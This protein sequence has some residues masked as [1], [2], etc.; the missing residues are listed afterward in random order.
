MNRVI[1]IGGLHGTG[2]S[3]TADIVAEH[4]DLRRVSA[5]RIFRG[6]A[7]ER[8]MTLEEFSK[9]AETDP[10]IDHELDARIKAEARKGSIVLDGQL[11]AWMADDFADL[12]VYLRAPTEVRVKRIASR[13]D[14]SFDNAMKETIV[15]EKIERERY[16][17]F[18][19]VDIRDL[20]IYDLIINTSIYDLEGVASIII[21]AAS[22]L[23]ENQP[24][25][26]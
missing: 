22:Y 20:E 19:G 24:P 16:E 18:Y 23:F 21:Q 6:L 3:S 11:A 4:F 10:D 25:T 13:D 14:V 7:E 26:A 17:E 8:E 15:R 5:G 2:K 1:T 12:K 9:V